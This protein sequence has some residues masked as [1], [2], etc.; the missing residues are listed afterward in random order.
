[1]SQCLALKTR[2]FRGFIRVD[3]N[4]STKPIEIVRPYVHERTT[5][6]YHLV[7]GVWDPC[8]KG[9]GA[10]YVPNVYAMGKENGDFTVCAS[11][12]QTLFCVLY[13]PNFRLF[14]LPLCETHNYQFLTGSLCMHVTIYRTNCSSVTLLY[15]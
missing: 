6:F 5:G 11:N 2:V 13:T 9:S 12:F 10:K 4:G 14:P 8:G 3:S 7:R 15:F 1:M